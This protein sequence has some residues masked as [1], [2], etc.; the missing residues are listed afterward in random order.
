MNTIRM[1]I[2]TRDASFRATSA[3]IHGFYGT[4]ETL[5][6]VVVTIAAS[7]CGDTV[8][9][10]L[11]MT[12]KAMFDINTVDAKQ[13]IARGADSTAT[14]PKKFTAIKQGR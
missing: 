7:Y 12:L 10:S 6:I 13:I 11:L 5:D 3:N 1:G 9:T 4:G 2:R 14:I 8:G